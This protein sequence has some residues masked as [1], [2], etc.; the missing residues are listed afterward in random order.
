[1]CILLLAS[2]AVA[3]SSPARSIAD[4]AG[5]VR[6]IAADTDRVLITLSE[7]VSFSQ[8]ALP[9]D[10]QRNL[11]DRCYVDLTPA[12][13]DRQ[14]Q[15]YVA[16]D[17]AVILQV[18]ASQ[19]R[20]DTVRVV[21]DL[22]SSRE[23]QA[24][25]LSDPPRLQISIGPSAETPPRAD[26]TT[27]PAEAVVRVEEE[28]H[29]ATPPIALTGQPEEAAAQTAA[30]TPAPEETEAEQPTTRATAT[31]HPPTES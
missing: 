23:C 4:K 12:I 21:L 2:T 14:V 31:I 8:A 27:E 7:S 1:M 15:R 20:A 17:S 11:K 25:L 6:S 10:A 30:K 28:S 24:T 29:A 5:P 22:V 18:R 9:G 13:L 26:A 19:F 16:V 3:S